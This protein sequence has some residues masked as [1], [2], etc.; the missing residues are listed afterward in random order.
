MPNSGDTY[1]VF[2][3]THGQHGL[4]HQLAGRFFFDPEGAIVVLE[5]YHGLLQ[6]L[7]GPVTSA[8]QALL[9]SLSRSAYT[10]VVRTADLH[11]GSRPELLPEVDTG[12]AS[13][14]A[15]Q[16]APVAPGGVPQLP[17]VWDYHRPGMETP[18]CL[19]WHRGTGTA[20]LNGQA[21]GDEELQQLLQ[22]LAEGTATLRYR[23]TAA[24]PGVA[25]MEAALGGEPLLLLQKG[26]DPA[27]DDLEEDAGMPGVGNRYAYAQWLPKA[28]PGGVHLALDAN[29]FSA[30]NEAYGQKVGDEAL[31]AIGRAMRS[32]LGEVAGKKETHLFRLGGD[33]FM[34]YVPTFEHAAH[35]ARALRSR[36]EAIPAVGGTHQLGM[37]LGMGD[38]PGVA[39]RSLQEHRATPGARDAVLG[40]HSLVPGHT[41]GFVGTA[42]A[43]ALRGGTPRGPR[44]PSPRGE[45]PSL[46]AA[47]TATLQRPH[48]EAPHVGPTSCTAGNPDCGR[49][50][51]EM[52]AETR[53]EILQSDVDEPLPG[54][55]RCPRCLGWAEKPKF[56]SLQ[57]GGQTTAPTSPGLKLVKAEGNQRGLCPAG[58]PRCLEETAHW[59]SLGPEER[60]YHVGP[61]SG[62][63]DIPALR[64]EQQCPGCLE[65][66]NP[67]PAGNPDCRA[68]G[69][70][71]KGADE[72]YL[73]QHFPVPKGE[74]HQVCPRCHET[75]STVKTR[76]VPTRG[77]GF[78][79]DQLAVDRA[80]AAHRAG[81]PP[82]PVVLPGGGQ[83]TAPASPGLKLV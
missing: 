57:G 36:L 43:R 53:A 13:G 65:W 15:L 4:E 83:T 80:L 2:R 60:Q 34:A 52:D 70:D 74:E 23:G 72:G 63:G 48:E 29:N 14:N 9:A 77:S 21:L 81:K 68:Q 24:L 76:P 20:L 31:A 44:R 58:N 73:Q 47:P 67:C 11:D 27:N 79:V 69:W 7:S 46:D 41:H 45:V 6:G 66:S 59:D 61:F 26:E 56:Q 10:E 35:F 8:S 33:N 22:N 3:L 71:L 51:K 50:A 54:A 39:Q 78:A 5:D 32:A 49:D 1:S 64:G 19:E 18:S 38:S 25:K 62:E 37:S 42:G 55:S 75:P 82:P 28:G 17:P 40:A 30:V 16:G 12:P